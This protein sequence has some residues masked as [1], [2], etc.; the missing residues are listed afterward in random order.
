MA[1]G[2][3]YSL[4]SRTL[5]HLNLSNVEVRCKITDSVLKELEVLLTIIGSVA[6]KGVKTL[7]MRR[8][9]LIEVK[10]IIIDKWSSKRL[11]GGEDVVNSVLPLIVD[12]EISVWYQS[13]HPWGGVPDIMIER[14]VPEI[15]DNKIVINGKVMWRIEKIGLRYRLRP[16]LWYP[17]VVI[18]VKSGRCVRIRDYVAEKKILV[19][20]VHPSWES[21]PWERVEEIGEVVMRVL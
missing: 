4:V 2:P 19:G 6:K 3:L 11:E 20:C 18:E 1:V 15:E 16:G 14:G 10:G 17:K 7:R 9:K 13:F 12:N 21:F 8:G 5:S